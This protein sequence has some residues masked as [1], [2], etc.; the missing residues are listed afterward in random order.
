[1]LADQKKT[2]R[3]RRSFRPSISV[4]GA[5]YDRLRGAY[6]AGSMAAFIDELVASTLDDPAAAAR[7]VARCWESS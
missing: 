2:K 6:P 4:T 3:R 5:V 7:V 1:M